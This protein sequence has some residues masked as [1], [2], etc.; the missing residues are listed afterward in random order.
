M[1][2][3]RQRQPVPS[4]GEK[5]PLPEISGAA[6]ADLGLRRRY[7]RGPPRRPVARLQSNADDTPWHLG[8]EEVLGRSRQCSLRVEAH[9]VSSVHAVLRHD[10]RWRIRDAS[11]LNGTFVDGARLEPGQEVVLAE[12]STV[13]LGAHTLFTLTDASPPRPHYIDEAG[14]QVLGS[15]DFL[16]LQADTA[17]VHASPDGTWWLEDAQGRRPVHDGDV[18]PLADRAT[19]VTL[20]L[21]VDVTPT[22][23]DG[24]H[25]D[26]ADIRAHFT[27]SSDEEHVQ[28]RLSV[29]QRSWTLPSRAHHYTL[30][31][32]ARQRLADRAA[33]LP[34][35]QQGW[36]DREQLLSLLGARDNLLHTHLYRA[37]RELA[38]LGFLRVNEVVE[39]RLDA[40][41]LRLGWHRIEVDTPS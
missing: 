22:H 3:R 17:W 21:P 41:Q 10:G 12:G 14:K 15:S 23:H 29:G 27:V 13:Q 24:A 11:S 37:R 19:T 33:G 1:R 32:L 2:L 38:D 6:R 5:A 20:R 28:L 16:T 40:G 26:V 8:P 35:R 31:V 30:L 7:T 36:L 4:I 25:F 34:R 39:R 18:V 9:D